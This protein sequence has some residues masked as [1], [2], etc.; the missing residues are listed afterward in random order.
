MLVP[1]TA[2]SLPIVLSAVAV[3]IASS[4]IHMV[5]GW[6]NSDY[7]KMPGEDDVLDAMRKAGVGPGDY[8]FPCAENPADNMRSE[9]VI[10][11]WKT[12]PA[13]KMTL[14]PSGPPNMGRNLA[15]WLVYSLVIGVLAGY[16][17]AAT[18]EP[19]A[20]YLK[21]FQVVGTVAFLAY[22][23]S[24][25]Q[26]VIWWGRGPGAAFKDI[27]DGLVYGLL[28]AGVFGWLWP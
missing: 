13:G 26:A 14:M 6:H 28:T 9:E 8:I 25:W 12:G 11:K 2:L 5:I 19:G 20:E 27:L 16:V 15:L 4:L 23:G 1:L 21:V 17:A 10:E 24:V 22:A 7:R 18:L 3:F